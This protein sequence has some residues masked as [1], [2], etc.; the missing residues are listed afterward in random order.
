MFDWEYYNKLANSLFKASADRNEMDE[1]TKEACFRSAISRAY[2]FLFHKVKEFSKSNGYNYKEEFKGR[3]HEE[4]QQ[5]LFDI[6]KSWESS[7]F[8]RTKKNR[9]KCDY[10]SD[11]SL[12]K[13]KLN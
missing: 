12:K 8:S 13:N 10:N 3:R 9:V 4:M 2:Y 7:A 6:S 5:Y 1:E 11:I